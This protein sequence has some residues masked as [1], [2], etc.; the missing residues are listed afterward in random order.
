MA[1]KNMFE[2][3]ETAA[4]A[5]AGHTAAKAAFDEYRERMWGAHGPPPFGPFPPPGI[6]VWPYAPP[7]PAGD[8]PP[9]PAAPAR[10]A[11]GSGA[12]LLAGLGAMIRLGVDLINT[13]LQGGTQLLQALSGTPGHMAHEAH[14]GCPGCAVGHHDCGHAHGH[15][16][17]YGAHCC[18]PCYPG[19]HNC[20]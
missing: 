17:L 6:S 5:A 18:N 12:S 20:P 8:W 3:P 7:P 10:R 11:A 15:H 14:G 4:G 2:E 9:P 16:C 13:G 19:V 1:T